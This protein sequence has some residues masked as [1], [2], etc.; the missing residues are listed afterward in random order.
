MSI[1][2]ANDCAQCRHWPRNTYIPYCVSTWRARGHCDL[3]DKIC[4]SMN[5]RCVRIWTAKYIYVPCII[6]AGNLQGQ[7]SAQRLARPVFEHEEHVAEKNQ[8]AQ[9]NQ[10]QEETENKGHREETS[11]GQEDA[12]GQKTCASHQRGHVCLYFEIVRRSKQ[13]LCGGHQLPSA[14]IATT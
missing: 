3:L 8:D 4:H 2:F 5:A 9:G 1:S 6:V 7:N 13:V 14:P 11:F 12:Q 10:G